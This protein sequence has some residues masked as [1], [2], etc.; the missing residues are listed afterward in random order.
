[1]SNSSKILSHTEVEYCE[2]FRTLEQSHE[3]LRE[4]VAELVARYE[5]VLGCLDAELIA[6]AKAA[7]K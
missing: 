5:Q 4:L 7:I 1:M 2:N 3:A 6:R